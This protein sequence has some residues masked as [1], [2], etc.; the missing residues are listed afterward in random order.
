MNN[1]R[2]HP[3]VPDVLEGRALELK[4][5]LGELFEERAFPL[6]ERVELIAKWGEWGG[7][8]KASTGSVS[9]SERTPAKCF[10]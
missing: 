3:R 1:Y 2:Q 7:R 10:P 9:G 5:G 8:S 4:A 6:W